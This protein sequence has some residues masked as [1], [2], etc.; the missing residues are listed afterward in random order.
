[1]PTRSAV[2]IVGSAASEKITMV[3]FLKGNQEYRDQGEQ[4][5]PRIR[6]NLQG[7]G[8]G[9]PVLTTMELTYIGNNWLVDNPDPSQPPLVI[10]ADVFYIEAIIQALQFWQAQ[11][12]EAWN[13]FHCPAMHEIYSRVDPERDE[14]K[15]ELLVELY[16]EAMEWL[17]ERAALPSSNWLEELSS[18]LQEE[19][20]L[21]P[22]T[23]ENQFP[24]LA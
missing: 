21:L 4:R 24:G 15:P 11:G 7:N 20:A 23:I 3:L 18:E 5:P 16:L 9:Q 2:L 22:G 14:V 8:S 12:F 1:M 13:F 6:A 10:P 19:F 17:F